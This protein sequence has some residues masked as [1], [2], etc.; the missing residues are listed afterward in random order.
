MKNYFEIFW[1]FLLLGMTSFGG[2]MAHLG[3]FRK[4]FVEKLKWIDEATYMRI[5]ALSQFLPG[6]S[7]SQVGFSIGARR[8]GILGGALASI[9][10]TLPSFLLLYFLA[11]LNISQSN[12]EIVFGI[13]S[14]L[15]LFAVVIVADATLG[16]FQKFCKGKLTLFI[17][18][19]SSVLLLFVQNF[20]IQILVI[21]L[22]SFVGI[23]F[24]K[25]QIKPQVK[26][27]QNPRLGLFILFFTIL[28]FGIFLSYLHPLIELFSAY[29]Q[30]GSL[31]FGGGHVLLPLIAQTSTVDENTFLVGYAFAQAVP[32]PMF[33]IVTYLGALSYEM[34][35]IT[36]A[37]IATLGIFLPGFLLIIIFEKSFDSYSKNPII[38]KALI[39]VN[40]SVVAIIFAALCNPIF[41]SGVKSPVDFL[42]ATLGF[43][44]LRKY[45]I[46]I[47]VLIGIFCVYGVF[48][49]YM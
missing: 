35:P 25:P 1:R 6:P 20:L 27:Y 34:S 48:A 45:N 17:F 49:L 28:F 16:M 31:V 37:I 38:A 18:I 26:S 14:G 11:T 23:L 36:G 4:N 43:L 47:L 2:P 46:S 39:G 13:T 41:P 29:Y 7:S 15:K 32:G 9:A 21:L 44:L 22:A 5:I 24:A 12:N 30:M 10:F 42:V 3:Y 40:A 33:T 19:F 8:G